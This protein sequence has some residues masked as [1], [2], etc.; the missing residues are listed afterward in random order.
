MTH[1]RPR[2]FTERQCVQIFLTDDFTFIPLFL[3]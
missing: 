3:V 1:K 2:R